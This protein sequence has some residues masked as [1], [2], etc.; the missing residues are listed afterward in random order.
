MVLMRVVLDRKTQPF[1]K[2]RVSRLAYMN[3]KLNC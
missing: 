3:K 2:I 1:Y